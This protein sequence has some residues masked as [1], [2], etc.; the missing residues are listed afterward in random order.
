VN[1]EDVLEQAL[2]G[3]TLIVYFYMLRHN[4]PISAREL[5]RRVGLS[6][7]SLVLHHLAKLQNLDLVATAEDGSY[8]LCRKVKV[9]VLRFFVGKGLLLMPQYVLY[10][11]FMSS[12]LIMCWAIFGNTFTAERVLLFFSLAFSSLVFWIE[13]YRVWKGRPI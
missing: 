6:S 2:T 3:K 9:G 8:I 7:P 5:Q 13:A 10:S 1:T 4:S 11:V 12:L